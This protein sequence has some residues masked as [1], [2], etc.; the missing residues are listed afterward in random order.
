[1][2]HIKNREILNHNNGKK[3][4]SEFLLLINIGKILF[5]VV[6][7][8]YEILAAKLCLNLSA[9]FYSIHGQRGKLQILAE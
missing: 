6:F 1:M 2:L 7:V 9:Y 8:Y 4:H 5:F 3:L